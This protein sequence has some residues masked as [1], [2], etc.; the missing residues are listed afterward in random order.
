MKTIIALIFALALFSASSKAQIF[1][2]KCVMPP[3]TG[4]PA[5]NLVGGLFKPESIDKYTNDPNA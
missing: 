1:D 5:D 4:T 3:D 2:F